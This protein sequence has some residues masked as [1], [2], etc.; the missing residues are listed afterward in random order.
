MTCLRKDDILR[1][2]LPDEATFSTSESSRGAGGRN[3]TA[4]AGGVHLRRAADL[5]RAG[6]GGQR[7]DAWCC[8]GGESEDD[9]GKRRSACGMVVRRS[10][11]SDGD[12]VSAGFDGGDVFAGSGLRR[13]AVACCGGD[14][15]AEAR[16]WRH[17][18]G[19]GG[20]NEATFSTSESSRGA[21][22]RNETAAAGGV[23]LRRAADLSRAGHGGQRDDAWCCGGGES[24]DDGGK[25]RSACGMVVRRSSCSDGDGVSAGFDGGDVFAGSGLR[26][27]AVACCGGDGWAE[28]RVWRHGDGMGGRSEDRQTRQPFQRRNRAAVLA[29][30]M[31]R[32]RPEV[33]TCDEQRT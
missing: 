33:F 18:D 10:S 17:G 27:P 2:L 31:K 16:V 8:G 14:G 24:E 3:E 13:P 12:G 21:G 1:S 26:R 28:A 15:W 5:S 9:G 23:H 25:R 32:R 7:D 19:M 6:H 29:D 20:R 11:C 4:A 30:E 22:G